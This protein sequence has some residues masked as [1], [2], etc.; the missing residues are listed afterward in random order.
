[1]R[2]FQTYTSDLKGKKFDAIVIGSG[3][4]GLATAIYLQKHG[5]NVLVLEQH[6]IPG[7]FTHTFHRK[8]FEWDIGVH[9]IGN[10]QE[11]NSN[12][13]NT[14]AYLTNNRL[15]WESMGYVYD[16]VMFGSESFDFVAGLEAQKHN[17]IQYFPSEQL[18]IEKYFKLLYSFQGKVAMYFGEKAMPFWLSKS[19]GWLLRLPIE[20]YFKKTT[21]SVLSEFINNDKLLYLL[22]A[23][24]GNYGLPPK[25][26]PFAIHAIVAGHY[27]NGGWYPIGGS[28]QINHTMAQHFSELGGT[29]ACNAFVKKIVLKQKVAIGVELE[30]GDFIP[31]STVVSTAGVYNTFNCLLNDEP[32]FEEERRL[33]NHLKP[34]VSHVCV[35]V[36]LK[37]GDAALSL[38]RHNI[39]CFPSHDIDAA[40]NS[41]TDWKTQEPPLYY[42]SFPSAKDPK[43]QQE[44]PDIATIQIIVPSNFDWF[45]KW[46]N[47]KWGRRGKD[48]EAVKETIAK[49]VLNKMY[50]VLPQTIGFVEMYDVSSPLSTKHFNNYSHGEIYGLE[51]SEKRFLNHFIRAHTKAKGLFLSGQDITCVGVGGALASATIT[52]STILKKNLFGVKV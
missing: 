35:S 28:A 6:N 14:F 15:Q 42:F 45:S 25:K 2:F 33:C 9:Y 22:C 32:M 12:L 38:P 4:S 40:L 8:K 11:E 34:S 51:Q 41:Y 49:Y 50:E 46:E 52:A 27:V 10:L 31:C 36:G 39:W 47:T 18:A 44:N 26:S 13:R 16:K 3:V 21:Y 7:G 23:Q 20:S 1:M 48:Y 24:C 29:I 5:K 43:W 19:I 37:K 30:N 17:L